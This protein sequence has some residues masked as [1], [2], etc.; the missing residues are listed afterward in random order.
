MIHF[1]AVHAHTTIRKGLTKQ[2]QWPGEFKPARQTDS[3]GQ[4]KVLFFLN[5][6]LAE[7]QKQLEGTHRSAEPWFSRTRS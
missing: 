5:P 6:H 4:N 1:P 7:C 2:D 3:H